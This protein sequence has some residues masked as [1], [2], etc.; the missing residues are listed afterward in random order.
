MGR[1]VCHLSQLN[2]NR[3]ITPKKELNKLHDKP[4]IKPVHNL[5]LSLYI[6]LKALCGEIDHEGYILSG[7]DPKILDN[8]D[9][10][11]RPAIC[12]HARAS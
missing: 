10:T 11:R 5:G 12:R 8:L 7:L 4:L 6:R 3:G 2:N 1:F 9:I